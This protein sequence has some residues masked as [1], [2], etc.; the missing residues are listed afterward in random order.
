MLTP[1]RVLD[2]TADHSAIRATFL[3]DLGAEV[4][5]AD[6]LAELVIAGALE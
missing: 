6:Q 3:A 4:M 5:D 1:Y 2:L